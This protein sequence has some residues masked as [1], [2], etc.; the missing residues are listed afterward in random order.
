MRCHT[1][2]HVAAAGQDCE[3]HPWKSQVALHYLEDA[4]HVCIQQQ[5]L[6]QL[7]RIVLFTSAGYRDVLAV[8]QD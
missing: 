5:M 8:S 1:A 7:V 4:V 2:M 3:D 6:H